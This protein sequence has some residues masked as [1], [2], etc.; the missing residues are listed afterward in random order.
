MTV[1]EYLESERRSEF[2]HEYVDGELRRTPDETKR[3]NSIVTNV[4]LALGQIAQARACDVFALS[5]K[6]RTAPTR[7]RYP[8]VIVTCE[9]DADEYAV[10]EPCAILE[11]LSSTNKSTDAAR[12]LEEY[13]KLPSLQRY[14]MLRQNVRS[15]FLYERHPD[16]WRVQILEADGEISLPCLETTLNLEQVYAGLVG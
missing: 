10:F 13:L 15:A 11:V 4:V 5:I 8:N 14:V 9:T 3:H 2:R 16:G 6:L 7:F 1:D 12:K